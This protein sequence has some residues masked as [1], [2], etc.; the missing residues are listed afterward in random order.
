MC[1]AQREQL[2]PVIPHVELCDL[3]LLLHFAKRGEMLPLPQLTDQ[4][5]SVTTTQVFHLAINEIA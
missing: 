3:G 4:S 2:P 1:L 5:G